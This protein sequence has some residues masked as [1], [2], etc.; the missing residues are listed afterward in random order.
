MPIASTC[1][2]S[3]TVDRIGVSELVDSGQLLLP[4]QPTRE[5]SLSELSTPVLD[6]VR[7]ALDQLVDGEMSALYLWGASGSGRSLLLQA[8][9]NRVGEAVLL[10]MRHVVFMP[11]E[12]LDGL[13]GSRFVVLDDIDAIAGFP[14]WEEAVFHLLNRL[15][16][17]NGRLLVSAHTAPALTPIQLPDL[18]SRLAAMTVYAMPAPDDSLREALLDQAVQQRGWALA[19]DVRRYLIERGP[20]RLSSF[21]RLI[22]Q[23]DTTALRERRALTV[24]LVRSVLERS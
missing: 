6:P 16:A 11:P 3:S 1:T 13:E 4:L 19:D 5:V 7:S 22:D 21:L 20:R 18:R 8:F 2:A 12:L 24:P 23:L 15:Q 17:Q 10:P 9:C 14:A